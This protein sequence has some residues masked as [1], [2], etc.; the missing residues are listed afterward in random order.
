MRPVPTPAIRTAEVAKR[1]FRN[2]AAIRRRI[3]GGHLNGRNDA[4]TWATVESKVA[5]LQA[6]F[7]EADE[8][9]ETERLYDRFNALERWS[10]G[11]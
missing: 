7:C 4:S 1:E 3:E 2:L 10:V 5:A 6:F 8:T 11:L 9:P